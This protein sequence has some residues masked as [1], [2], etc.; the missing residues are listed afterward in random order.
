[1]SGTGTKTVSSYLLFRE[2]GY[3]VDAIKFDLLL[4]EQHTMEAEVTSHPVEDGSQI[5]DHVQIRPRKGSLTGFVTNHP[6]TSGYNG[7]LPVNIAQK[8]AA[9]QKKDWLSGF[10]QDIA[11]SYGQLGRLLGQ[12]D[13]LK[14]TESDFQGLPVRENR[15][16]NMFDAFEA[17]VLAKKVCTIQTGLKK[18]TDV[19]VTKVDTSRDKETGDAGKFKVDFQEIRFVTPS[20]IALGAKVRPNFK[21]DAGKQAAKKAKKGKTG[22]KAAPTLDGGTVTYKDGK[23]VHT[24]P[25]PAKA[26]KLKVVGGQVVKVLS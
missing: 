19:I 2:A 10:V 23:F 25:D 4:D 5:N 14:F 1:M 8:I 26:A 17:L 18:Y 22:G 16:Q 7:G 13:G 20:E 15:V 3:T 24:A 9:S 11:S 12:Q 6:F 21:T